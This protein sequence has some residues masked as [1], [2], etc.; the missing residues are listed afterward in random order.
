MKIYYRGFHWGEDWTFWRV[1]FFRKAEMSIDD[2]MDWRSVRRLGFSFGKLKFLI[3]F[4]G[5]A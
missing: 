5:R 4:T 3:L 2:C 1:D